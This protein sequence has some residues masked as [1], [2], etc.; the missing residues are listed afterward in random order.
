LQWWLEGKKEAIHRIQRE[1]KDA[2]YPG[3]YNEVREVK[4]DKTKHG[5]DQGPPID[6]PSS[7]STQN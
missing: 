3:S 6:V 5:E 4:A 2:H 1:K 7:L